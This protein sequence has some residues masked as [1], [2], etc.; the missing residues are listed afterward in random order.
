MVLITI[1]TACGIYTDNEAHIDVCSTVNQTLTNCT[2]GKNDT[3][4]LNVSDCLFTTISIDLL[5]QLEKISEL[6]LSNVKFTDNISLAHLHTLRLQNCNLTKIDLNLPNLKTVDLRNNPLNCCLLQHKNRNLTI[7]CDRKCGLN[8]PAW[9]V[10]A[11]FFVIGI[12]YVLLH[13]L[14]Y[15]C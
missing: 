13:L 12:L 3:G 9:I 10:L 2:V 11:G 6:D 5:S 14:V 8:E 1:T 4:F 7:T 15:G